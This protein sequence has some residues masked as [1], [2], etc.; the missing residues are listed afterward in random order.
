MRK[1][2]RKSLEE[3]AHELSLSV[4]AVKEIPL[5]RSHSVPQNAHTLQRDGID[6]DLMPKQKGHRKLECISEVI[7]ALEFRKNI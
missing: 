7:I 2:D 4:H 6:A 3:I 5:S 1:R